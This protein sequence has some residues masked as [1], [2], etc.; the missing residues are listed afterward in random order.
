MQ[1][2]SLQALEFVVFIVIIA[3]QLGQYGLWRQGRGTA[4]TCQRP[5]NTKHAKTASLTLERWGLNR[6]P[7][8]AAGLKVLCCKCLAP[9]QSNNFL[10]EPVQPSMWA[11]C[12]LFMSVWICGR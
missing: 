4:N 3:M 10:N 5:E 7:S 11:A 9:F 2:L 8:L 12:S 6:A 1:S